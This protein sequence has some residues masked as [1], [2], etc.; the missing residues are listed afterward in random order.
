[1]KIK[2]KLFALLLSIV[3]GFNSFSIIT[4]YADTQNS[5]IQNQTENIEIDFTDD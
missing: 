2:Y 4:S 1:M 5:V 3:L